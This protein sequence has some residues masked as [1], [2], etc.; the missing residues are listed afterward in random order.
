MVEEASSGR[1]DEASADEDDETGYPGAVPGKLKAGS[2]P[3]AIGAMPDNEDMVGKALLA[4][5]DE[6]TLSTMAL[7]EDSTARGVEDD[8]TARAVLLG[9][10]RPVPGRELL[11]L[12]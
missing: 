7:E 10:G 4:M 3:E 6:E 9:T 8:S 11:G 5:A 1:A 12:P 2:V